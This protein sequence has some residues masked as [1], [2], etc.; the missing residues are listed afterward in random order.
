MKRGNSWSGQ[1]G[2]RIDALRHNRRYRQLLLVIVILLF[3]PE[4]KGL[5]SPQ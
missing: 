4:T 3:A 1:V 2:E 5:E